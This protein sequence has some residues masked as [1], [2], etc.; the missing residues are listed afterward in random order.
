MPIKPLYISDFKWQRVQKAYATAVRGKFPY[1]DFAGNAEIPKT[2]R[3]EKAYRLRQRESPE[4]HH[5]EP[6]CLQRFGYLAAVLEGK[7]E[8]VII[9]DRGMI[10]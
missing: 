7:H 8:P 5:S 6:F 10:N 1:A 9:V 4:H 3:L 2:Y